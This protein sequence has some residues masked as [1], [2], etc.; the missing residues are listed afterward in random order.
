MTDKP[1]KFTQRGVKDFD[2]EQPSVMDSDMGFTDSV[3][4]MIESGFVP[5]AELD[6][7]SPSPEQMPDQ[8]KKT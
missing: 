1:I 4:R 8:K 3:R 7:E 2:L 6:G 5:D